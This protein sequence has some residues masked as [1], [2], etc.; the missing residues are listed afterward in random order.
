MKDEQATTNLTTGQELRAA[1]TVQPTGTVPQAPQ[2]EAT[3]RLEL[4]EH[5]NLLPIH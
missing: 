3:L 2:D 5:G 1:G 4:D